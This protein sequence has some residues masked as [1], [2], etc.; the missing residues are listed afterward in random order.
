V[1]RFNEGR[2]NID[3]AHCGKLSTVT[4]IEVKEEIN[5]RVR[6]N[7]KISTHEIISDMS[8]S[9]RKKLCKSGLR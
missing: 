7:R 6:D 4:C 8:T 3:D 9:Q 1:G 5:Q 2:V